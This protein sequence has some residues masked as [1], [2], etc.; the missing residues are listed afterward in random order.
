MT[1]A[2]RAVDALGDAQEAAE[3]LTGN[4]VEARA[5]K[6][7]ALAQLAVAAELRALRETQDTANLI[8]WHENL[9]HTQ[10]VPAARARLADQIYTRLGF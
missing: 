2:D 10:G 3:A 4:G 8:A 6:A 7:M 9:M 1:A 5:G